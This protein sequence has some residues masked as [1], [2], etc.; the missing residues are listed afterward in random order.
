MK[1][2]YSLKELPEEKQILAGGKARSLSYMI[3][4]TDLRIPCGYVILANALNGTQLKDKA[5]SELEQL[6]KTLNPKVT[7]A[8][9]SSAV[10]ED[11][12]NASFAGQYETITDARQNDIVDAVLKVAASAENANV[13]AYT[14]RHETEQYNNGIGIVIQEFVHAKFAGVLFT[15]DIITG[16]DEKMIGNYVHGEGEKLVSGAENAETFELNAIKYAY[17]G[18][19]E[20]RPFAKTLHKYCKKIRSLYGMPMDIE[21]AVADGKV[22]ILQAR[23]I[24]TL[25]RLNPDNYDINGT[26]SGYKLLTKTNVGEIFM[27]PISPMTF[28]VLEKINDILG[29][30]QWLDC[31]CGQAYMN[32]SVMCSIAVAF[33]SKKEKAY[34]GMKGLV[35]KAPEGVEVPISPFDK[36]QFIKKIWKL[37]FPKQKSKLTKKQKKEMVR[38]LAQIAGTMIEEIRRIESKEAL[39]DYWEKTMLPKLRDGMAAIVGQSGTSM[40]PLF[41]TQ[42]KIAKIAGEEMADRLCTGCLGVLE[43]M[44]PLFLLADVEQGKITKEE[45]IRICGHRC[46]NEME[47][48]EKRPYEDETYVDRLIEER[49]GSKLDMYAMEENQKKAYEE[50]LAEFKQKYPSKR[51]WI[52]KT[53]D[54]FVSASTFREDLRSKGVWIFCV[55]REYILRAGTLSGLGDNIF[56]LMF[57]E[58]FEYLKSNG[59]KDDRTNGQMK[60]DRTNGQMKDD[61]MNGTGGADDTGKSWESIITA[62]QAMYD[63]YLTYEQFPNIIMGR[64]DEQAWMADEHRRRDYFIQDMEPIIDEDA[65][66]KGFAGAAG[67]IQGKVRVVTDITEIGTIQEGEIL[68]TSATNVG[69][70][71]VFSKVS[72]IVTDIGAPLSHA[73]I[74][75][76]E[77]GI[78]AVVGC[79]NATMLLHTGDEVIVDGRAGTVKLV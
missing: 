77:C 73:A 52:D 55:F 69:W 51:R 15:S 39:Y 26:R 10:N 68:V 23:P 41:S 11:G 36:K 5:K 4:N 65:Q 70:T 58:L 43:S 66:I 42:K 50:S 63:R 48:M 1:Y 74:V 9:R 61:R 59:M 60:D 76:R 27:K 31:V 34:E 47:L 53:V 45:Y 75:A 18:P 29:L 14:Q 28:S 62:R 22:F 67:V 32:I 20:F 19:E 33:G 49:R 25:R 46:P 8:V 71:P 2:I 56:M 72:A 57:D 64:F 3:Q 6:I 54:K 78:P 13:K 30:P 37:F 40:V 12:D 16:K 38:D 7:Y 24:T 79:G 17:D 35:G 21:W 44:K